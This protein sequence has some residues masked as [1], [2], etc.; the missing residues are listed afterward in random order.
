[1]AHEL[2]LEVIAEGV[3]TEAQRNYLLD[4]GCDQ[5]QGYLFGRPQPVEELGK[6]LASK[7]LEGLG[8]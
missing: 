1:M 6:L 2:D 7:R 3:E 5:F 4:R 8:G